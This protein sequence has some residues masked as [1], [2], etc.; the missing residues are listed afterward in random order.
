MPQTYEFAFHGKRGL[1]SCDYDCEPW[2]FPGGSVV[3][4]LPTDA[5]DTGS[6]PVPGR[7]HMLRSN[8]SCAPELWSLCSGAHALQ[9]EKPRQRAA[10]AQQLESSP[11][12]ET[13]T[14][15][16]QK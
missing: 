2:G 5:G 13:K 6:I 15:H 11:R 14:Q 16:S 8:C 3:K 1:C 7:S 10:F 12:T 9:Q 4:N